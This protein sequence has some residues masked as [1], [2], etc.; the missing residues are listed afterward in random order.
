[1]SNLS[2]VYKELL[3]SDEGDTVV[4]LKDGK[5]PKT[6][7]YLIKK[8]FPVFKT[9]LES[10]MQE[11]AT[12]VVDLSSQYSLEAFREFMS[13]I[14]YNKHYAGSFVPLLFEILCISD[15]YGVEVYKK[16]I[17]DRISGLIKDVPICLTIASEALNHG[18]LI[19]K[20]YSTCLDFLAEA[21]GAKQ[22]CNV[23]KK[24]DIPKAE[25]KLSK[26]EAKL[27][28]A[29]AKLSRFERKLSKANEELSKAEAK[30]SRVER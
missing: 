12:G 25:A 26:A 5:Q 29:E 13:Y 8:R 4:K 19:S 23:V 11:S 20:I 22:D 1:M 16:Y 3:T 18:T 17:T 28:K 10:S 6:I 2:E 7:S 15:Y 14:Y 21:I 27:S 9:M 24:L 30:L